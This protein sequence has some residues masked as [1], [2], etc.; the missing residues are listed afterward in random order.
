VN[1]CYRLHCKEQQQKGQPV[2]FA[3]CQYDRSHHVA[4]ELLANHEADCPARLDA[5]D[6]WGSEAAGA[7]PSGAC[8]GASVA[9]SAK[10]TLPKPP[11]LSKE[12]LEA[13]HSEDWDSE[14]AGTGKP[15][16]PEERIHDLRTNGYN[17][18]KTHNIVGLTRSEKKD[19][20]AKEEAIMK[21]YEKNGLMDR[22]RRDVS[23]T[24]STAASTLTDAES[25]Y[26]DN[27]TMYSIQE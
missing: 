1:N 7:G 26:G 11:E 8:G 15:F 3:I 22:L 6:D 25:M 13:I 20:Y 17:Y 16:N 5:D 21:S 23:Q 4:K 14:P 18:I 19:F 27:Q 2:K 12:D 9:M 24:P 10:V